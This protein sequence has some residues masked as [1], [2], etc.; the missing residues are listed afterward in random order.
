[1]KHV[2]EMSYIPLK[3]CVEAKIRNSGSYIHFINMYV[4]PSKLVLIWITRSDVT[5]PECRWTEWILR[6]DPSSII[7]EVTSFSTP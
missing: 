6:L 1:M 7:F 3:V 4:L 5:K 2:S